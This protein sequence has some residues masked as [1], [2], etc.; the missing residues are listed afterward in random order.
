MKWLNY[1]MFLV[2]VQLI[3]GC[4]NQGSKSKEVRK[5]EPGTPVTDSFFL[6]DYKDS[7]SYALGYSVGKNYANMGLELR[8]VA[9][10]KAVED[11]LAGNAPKLD[12]NQMLA[13]MSAFQ[14]V[15]EKKHSREQAN[16]NAEFLAMNARFL[17]ENKV[18]PGIVELASGLQYQVLKEGI[19][20]KP[21]PDD[22]VTIHILASMLDGRIVQ[23]SRE[24]GQPYTVDFKPLIP[25]WREIL[26]MMNEGASYKIWCPPSLAYGENGI[27]SVV[28]PNA[29]VVFEIELLRVIAKAPNG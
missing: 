6:K 13:V 5:I 22:Q 25:A 19:G 7:L 24:R 26:P 28:G 23:N 21:T 29:V 17:A 12:D 11:G 16:K 15:L 4:G 2:L 20:P 10:T 9:Y 8:A 1:A 18:K 14:Q 3:L 27:P